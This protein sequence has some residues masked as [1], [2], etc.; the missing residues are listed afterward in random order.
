[1]RSK[2]SMSS[3][4]GG[5]HDYPRD[6]TPSLSKESLPP[7][8]RSSD[9]V[10]WVLLPESCQDRNSP[11]TKPRSEQ[12]GTIRIPSSEDPSHPCKSQAQSDHSDTPRPSYHR[13]KP[14]PGE[15]LH[16]K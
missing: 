16:A 1:M 12:P 2:C 8:A 9:P 14:N 3:H 13:P 10:C 4:L 5:I 7:A 6:S 11:S 15:Y